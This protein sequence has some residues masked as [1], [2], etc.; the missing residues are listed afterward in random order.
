MKTIGVVAHS[1]EGAGLCFVS[2]CRYGAAALG[3]HMH[4]TIALSAIPMA[5]SM[6]AWWSDK[7][8]DIV[9]HLRQGVDMVARS[10]ADFFVCPDNTAHIVLEQVIAQLSLP[11]LHIAHV[12]AEEIRR[13]GWS[14][15]GLL[16]TRWTMTGSVYRRALERHGVQMLVPSESEQ[17]PLN[18]AIFEELCNSRFEPATTD[19]F[20]KAIEGLK[21]SG[22]EC[23]ILGCTEI[24]LIINDGN[25]PLPVLDSTRL[26]A[27]YAVEVA[28]RDD[29]LPRVGWLSP[30]GDTEADRAS[31][32]SSLG[33]S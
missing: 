4:P 10:G 31:A 17:E 12:V 13:K 9:P 2:A 32:P 1:A 15:V 5:L 16:G 20:I 28:L 33:S 24:P 25:S 7:Y 22:A 29:P 18:A 6:P 14:R 8:E 11:G 30:S 3:D 19:L 21:R 26:L 23:V 27:A